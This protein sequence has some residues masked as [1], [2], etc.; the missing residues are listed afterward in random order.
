VSSSPRLILKKWARKW[1]ERFEPITSFINSLKIP[2][3][4][5]PFYA[6]LFFEMLVSD[7]ALN[8]ELMAMAGNYVYLRCGKLFVKTFAGV[9]LTPTAVITFTRPIK[10]QGE[11]AKFFESIT[12]TLETSY[13]HLP[14]DIIV[15][16]GKEIEAKGLSE[17]LGETRIYEV[18]VGDWWITVRFEP[19]SRGEVTLTLRE[20]GRIE[21]SWMGDIEKRKLESVAE[22]DLVNH[23]QELDEDLAKLYNVVW[24]GMKG[25]V[26]YVLY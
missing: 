22:Q 2:V 13:Y 5:V 23:L 15:Y 3:A 6:N 18:H 17:A 4:E 16:D 7:K 20:S 8:C 11:I 12:K 1:I 21:V 25:I 19:G 9:I 14:I 24:I 26:S 10:E